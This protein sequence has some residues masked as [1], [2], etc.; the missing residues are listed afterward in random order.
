MAKHKRPILIEI[1]IVDKAKR[2]YFFY[3]METSPEDRWYEL[4]GKKKYKL[5]K[6]RIPLRLDRTDRY[7][8]RITGRYF[9]GNNIAVEEATSAV[10]DNSLVEIILQNNYQ[11]NR[12]ERG[13]ELANVFLKMMRDGEGLQKITYS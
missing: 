6:K 12:L 11:L 13:E 7:L 3:P 5:K 8:D 10:C 4:R 1:K 9:N 2:T